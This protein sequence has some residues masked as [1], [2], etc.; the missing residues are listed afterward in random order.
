[1]PSTSTPASTPLPASLF[2]EQISASGYQQLVNCPYQFFAARCLKLEPP[3]TIR[4]M[5]EKSDYGERVHLCLHA[6]HTNVADLPGPFPAE[7]SIHN[8]KDATQ[9][10]NDIATAV[11]AQDLEDNFLHRGWLQRWQEMIPEYLHWQL[12]HQVEWQ[13]NSTEN[14][15]KAP[16]PNDPIKLQGRLDRIDANK[17]GLGIIDY[18]TGATPHDED[19]LNGEAVQLPFYALLAEQSLQ[20][21]VTRVEYVA[22][23][24]RSSKKRN[25]PKVETV[26]T[27]E[28]ETLKT[29]TL[30]TAARLD[31]LATDLKSG[32]PMPAWGD[33]KTCEYCDMDGLCRKQSWSEVMSGES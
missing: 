23:D 7:L 15:L 2:P 8:I 9:C 12:E 20:K 21:T 32:S 14:N 26:G 13:I 1:M 25:G 6:F 24:N 17:D 11:F 10:L 28:G 31:K 22:L 18:K 27:L 33:E 29:L 5:L 19:V 30:A 4:E 16:R 3:E